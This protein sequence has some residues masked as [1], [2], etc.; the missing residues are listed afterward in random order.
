MR[1]KQDTLLYG[2]YH[3]SHFTDKDTEV[4]GP[5]GSGEN[6]MSGLRPFHTQPSA[7]PSSCPSHHLSRAVRKNTA[8]E[9]AKEEVT[10]LP[11]VLCHTAD[12]HR[13]SSASSRGGKA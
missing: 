5:W 9:G 6:P 4:Q 10:P 1:I 7:C 12:R 3:Y 8:N 13:S 11:P 2:K